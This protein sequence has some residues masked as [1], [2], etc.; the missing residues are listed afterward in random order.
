[1][2]HPQYTLVK[3]ADETKGQNKT[4]ALHLYL[5]LNSFNMDKQYPPVMCSVENAQGAR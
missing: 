3:L 2:V 1:M 4:Q 5:Y